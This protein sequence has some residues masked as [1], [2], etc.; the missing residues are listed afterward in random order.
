MKN[1]IFLTFI[2]MFPIIGYSYSHLSDDQ[3]FDLACEGIDE[4]NLKSKSEKLDPLLIIGNEKFVFD[5]SVNCISADGC[6]MNP[7]SNEQLKRLSSFKSQ[8]DQDILY[9]DRIG[10]VLTSKEM[11]NYA[12][13]FTN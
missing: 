13:G 2:L 11:V 10:I 1:K 12:C 3:M 6:K 9:R 7:F 4:Y 8:L 5:Y